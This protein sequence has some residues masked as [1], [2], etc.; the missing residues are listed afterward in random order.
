MP[1]RYF[2]FYQ[3]FLLPKIVFI[4]LIVFHLLLVGVGVFAQQLPKP[5]QT[6]RMDQRFKKPLTP[7][8]KLE[9]LPLAPREPQVPTKMKEIKFILRGVLVEGSTIYKD[10]EFLNLYEEFLGKEITLAKIYTFAEAIT[11]KYR[12][13]GYLITRALVPAQRIIDGVVKIVV[14]EGYINELDI[15][16]TL[17]GSEQKIRA[18]GEKIVNVRPLNNK[19]LERYLLLINDL[20]GVSV[21]SVLTPSKEI[22]GASKL[23]LIMD[24]KAFDGF[25]SLDNRG[26]RFSGPFQFSLGGSANSFLGLYERTSINFI[27]AT[28]PKELIY[29]SGQHEQQIGSE[30]TKVSIFG[31]LSFTEPGHTLAPLNVEGDSSTFSVSLWQPFIRSRRQNLSGGLT[32]SHKNFQT[33]ILGTLVSKDRL[34]VLTFEL[35]F[36]QADRFQGITLMN[37]Q[38]SQGVNVFDA[39]EL[40]SPNLSRADGKSD[41]SKILINLWRLQQIVSGWSLFVEAEVQWAFSSLLSAEEFA[42]GGPR[43]GRGY[44]PSEITG[45]HG[46]AFKTELQYS[47][48]L[49]FK[50]LKSMQIYTFFDF[51]SVWQKGQ[52]TGP[53]KRQS[54][55][56]AGTGVRMNF[57]QWLSGYLEIAKPFDPVIAEGDENFR[58][59]GSLKAVF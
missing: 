34:R 2:S 38:F 8:S 52:F 5:G 14:I 57:T 12:N 20:P 22:H 16:G 32:F 43:F 29:F 7:K 45:D 51:G 39:T 19:I 3:T 33:D 47:K 1:N 35:T 58:L 13:E 24:H 30:G 15:Q 40:G 18:Y 53:S 48:N 59:F 36:D 56:S 55:A 54:L 50:Y 4:L 23:T 11:V 17:G 27:T 21:E 10:R 9:E 26:S 6:E 28:Q 42:F 44:D 46:M 49:T 25:V 41:F 31:S 37:V